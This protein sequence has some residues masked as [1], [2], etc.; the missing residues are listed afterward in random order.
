MEKHTTTK[1]SWLAAMAVIGFFGVIYWINLGSLNL[2]T[3]YDSYLYTS[4][5][6]YMLD[7]RQFLTPV[8]RGGTP[9]FFKPP[10]TYWQAMMGMEIFGQSIF[11]SRIGLIVAQLL[12]LCVFVLIF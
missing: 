10:A 3:N 8:G 11:A 7:Y 2:P 1:N 5:A 12:S 6:K 4:I 9:L